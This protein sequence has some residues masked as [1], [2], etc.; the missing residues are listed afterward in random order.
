MNNPKINSHHKLLAQVNKLKR[1]LARKDEDFANTTEAFKWDAAQSYLVGFEAAT[2]QAS[3]LHSEID[4]SE[5][6]PG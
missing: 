1:E 4:Y 6:G 2:E 3:R 5:L